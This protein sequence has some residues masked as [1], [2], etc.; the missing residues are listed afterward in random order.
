MNTSASAVLTISGLFLGTQRQRR[1]GC[2]LTCGSSLHLQGWRWS[3]QAGLQGQMSR[4]SSLAPGLI[5]SPKNFISGRRFEP[6]SVSWLV[7]PDSNIKTLKAQTL[8]GA[9]ID[10]R[11]VNRRSG[12]AVKKASA[13]GEDPGERGAAVRLPGRLCSHSLFAGV[14]LHLQR[15]RAGS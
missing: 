8:T 11:G 10:H 2:D 12:G 5:F 9:P 14:F 6:K 15:G 3:L 4:V 7:I 13:A 1:N